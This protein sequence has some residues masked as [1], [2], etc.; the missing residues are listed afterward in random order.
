[1]TLPKVVGVDARLAFVAVEPEGGDRGE[2][3]RSQELQEDAESDLGFVG[4]VAES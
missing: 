2:A 1:M 4:A 3:L